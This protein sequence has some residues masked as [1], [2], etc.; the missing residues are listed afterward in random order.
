[1]PDDVIYVETSNKEP[2]TI[3]VARDGV[4][5]FKHS[6]KMT[7]QHTQKIVNQLR[8]QLPNAEVRTTFN[9]GGRIIKRNL[10]NKRTYPG[11]EK[12][13]DVPVELPTHESITPDGEPV[14]ESNPAP[15]T[16]L[17]VDLAQPNA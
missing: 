14:S 1:M 12:W 8:T 6:E 5:I 10:R 17:T 15:P 16:I 13:K 4:C 7:A 9:D 11:D 2:T 3:V